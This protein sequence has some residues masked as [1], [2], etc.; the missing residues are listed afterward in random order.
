MELEERESERERE[1]D[2]QHQL[3][4]RRLKLEA[5]LA[6]TEPAQSR[7]SPLRVDTAVKLI[8]TFTEHGIESFF[9]LV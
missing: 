7:P 8:P 5:G 9:Y 1:R 4:L 2:R 3:E 6:G